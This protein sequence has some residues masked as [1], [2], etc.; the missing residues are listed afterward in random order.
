MTGM[1][2]LVAPRETYQ[3]V[4]PPEGNAAFPVPP[5]AVQEILGIVEDLLLDSDIEYNGAQRA[6]GTRSDQSPLVLGV[7]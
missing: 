4:S 5:L 1:W 3:Q 2:V 6:F 7:G